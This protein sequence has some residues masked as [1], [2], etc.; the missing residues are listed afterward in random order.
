MP[1]P[2]FPV[3]SP[4]PRCYRTRGEL[5]RKY[6]ELGRELG[7]KWRNGRT[8]ERTDG[9]TGEMGNSFRADLIGAPRRVAS[10]P[11]RD[12]TTRDG[13]IA[14]AERQFVI[15]PIRTD[16][17]IRVCRCA[18]VVKKNE[19]VTRPVRRKRDCITSKEP[20]RRRRHRHREQLRKVQK[21]TRLSMSNKNNN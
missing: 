1:F 14:S 17:D 3:A 9:R 11:R 8:N 13:E 21:R 7:G 4:P 20:P 19:H 15:R 6:N 16:P 5:T 2:S 10:H 18:V 12:A